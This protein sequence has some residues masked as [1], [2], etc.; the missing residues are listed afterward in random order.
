MVAEL[1]AR[2]DEYLADHTIRCLTA[3]LSA[4]FA[5]AVEE[6]VIPVNVARDVRLPSGR[7]ALRRFDDEDDHDDPAPGKAKALTDTELAAFLLVVDPRWRLFFE[8]LA[9]TGL[10]GVRGSR[11]R[12]HREGGRSRPEPSE[13]WARCPA[14]GGCERG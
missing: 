2:N 7:D 10:R 8:L 14:W 6:G 4:L 1:A 12:A 5:S 11:V 13:P 3:P 9:A